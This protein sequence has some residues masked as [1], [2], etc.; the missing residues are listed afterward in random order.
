MISAMNRR[1]AGP[2]DSGYTLLELAAVIAIVLILSVA[3]VA[4]VQ[5]VRKAD[6][7]T[8]AARVAACVR[9]LYDLAVLNNRPYRLVMDL[10]S[11]S[12]WGELAQDDQRCGGAALLPGEEER[13]FGL[14][15]GQG[16]Q[17][18]RASEGRPVAGARP[19]GGELAGARP[20]G[21]ESA[22]PQSEAPEGEPAATTTMMPKDNLLTKR[23]LPKGVKFSMVMTS[24]QDEPTEEGRAEIYFFPSGYVERAYV[25]LKRDDNVYTVETV[26]LRGVGV[27]HD[28]EL[29]PKDIL[30]RE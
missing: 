1:G 16:A 3:S 24:H 20:G 7:S 13:K 19:G 18:G 5:S 17:R 12:Y 25:F 14:A 6:I 15:A 22:G 27:V 9:Y 21:G 30:D 11:G 10:S 8:A 4:T 29:D 23:E 2:L 26:P 28:R